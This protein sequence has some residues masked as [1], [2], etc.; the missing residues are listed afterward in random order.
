M[1]TYHAIIVCTENNARTG[2]VRTLWI[3]LMTLNTT[4]RLLKP[5]KK[6]IAALA[7]TSGRFSIFVILF[8]KKR[9]GLD[10]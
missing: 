3:T 10:I 4:R 1:R 7:N 6:R 8:Y 2:F 5:S 9:K